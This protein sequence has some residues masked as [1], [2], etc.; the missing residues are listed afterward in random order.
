MVLPGGL[1]V[2][3]PATETEGDWIQSGIGDKTSEDEHEYRV[4]WTVGSFFLGKLRWL[5]GKSPL[6]KLEIHEKLFF[7]SSIV[8]LGVKTQGSFQFVSFSVRSLG[9]TKPL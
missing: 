1:G 7:F 4:S 5:A 9:K 2:R 3:F 8:M 6:D